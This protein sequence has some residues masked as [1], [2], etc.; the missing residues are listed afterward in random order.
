MDMRKTESGFEA[1]S[2]KSS[3]GLDEEREDSN[4]L[5]KASE[6]VEVSATKKSV[7]VPKLIVREKSWNI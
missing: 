4:G 3:G 6:G 5:E 7:N 1:D 2:G